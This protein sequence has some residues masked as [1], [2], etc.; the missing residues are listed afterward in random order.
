M[1]LKSCLAGMKAIQNF[2][3]LGAHGGLDSC[4]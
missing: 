1:N 2:G 4:L 3:D